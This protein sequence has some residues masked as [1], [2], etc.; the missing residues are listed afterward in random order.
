MTCVRARTFHCI[1]MLSI[2]RHVVLISSASLLLHASSL[3]AVQPIARNGPRISA[4]VISPQ[5][6]VPGFSIQRQEPGWS[7]VSPEGK[8]FFSFGVCCVQ[9][10]TSRDE[11][12]PENP[13]YAAWQHYQDDQ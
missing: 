1:Q 11:F 4:G 6:V 13:G 10:G 9:Q 12:D 8:P 2:R 3:A 5:P 7:F